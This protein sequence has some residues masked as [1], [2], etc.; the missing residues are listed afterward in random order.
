MQ[1]LLLGVRQE[2]GFA[3]VPHKK[4]SRFLATLVP[5]S[6]LAE[7]SPGEGRAC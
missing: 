1:I 6:Y 7:V 4:T 3:V 2:E 5:G